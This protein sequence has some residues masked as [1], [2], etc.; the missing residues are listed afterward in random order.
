MGDGDA[1]DLTPEEEFRRRFWDILCD[2][3]DYLKAAVAINGL[4][5]A[6]LL[7]ASP[8][9]EPGSGSFVV[10][11][12]DLFI[13]LPLLAVTLFLVWRCGNREYERRF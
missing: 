4:L 8:G 13:L 12:I 3:E 6:L 9:I 2:Y 5:L 11:T 10:L 7:L 1:G